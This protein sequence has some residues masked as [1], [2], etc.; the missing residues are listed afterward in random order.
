MTPITFGPTCNFD[1]FKAQEDDSIHDLS[2]I[3]NHS[4]RVEIM[5]T[6][7]IQ[8]FIIKACEVRVG[9]VPTQT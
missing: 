7:F 1:D 3:W 4:P 2:A 6:G 5:G 8:D 9:E